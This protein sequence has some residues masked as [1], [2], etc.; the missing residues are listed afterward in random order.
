VPV[1]VVS[2]TP[3]IGTCPV[4]PSRGFTGLDPGLFGRS[5]R[6][7]ECGSRGS[8]AIALDRHDRAGANAVRL[9]WVASEDACSALQHAHS[10]TFS[11]RWLL[12]LC[13]RRERPKVRH[14]CQQS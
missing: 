11:A 13:K 6:I 12:R 9:P 3:G 7:P 1:T 5:Q 2:L 14:G 10:L 8:V 4:A